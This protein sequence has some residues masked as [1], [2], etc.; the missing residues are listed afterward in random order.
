MILIAIAVLIVIVSSMF[1]SKLSNDGYGAF[2][3]LAILLV[4]VGIAFPLSGYSESVLQSECE[5]MP[6]I[7]GTD[8]YILKTNE[9]S[10][11]CRY[12]EIVVKNE[13]PTIVEYDSN[14]K[15]EVD[16]NISK[17]ILKTYSKKPKRSLWTFA[18]VGNKTEMVIYVPQAKIIS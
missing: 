2:V 5:L 15:I 11:I 18:L 9:G 7:D 13:Y 8:T 10:L 14:L 16:N 12:N 4:V 1:I 3:V 6:I 17:P